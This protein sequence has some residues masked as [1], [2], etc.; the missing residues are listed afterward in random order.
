MF[1][2]VDANNF[3]V[4]CERVFNPKLEGRP[5]V[6]LSNNDGCAVAR[7][8]E[9]KALGVKMGAPWFAM[10]ELAKKHGIVA[11]S[12]NYTLYGDMSDRVV[13]IL[14]GY[15]PHVEVYSIDESFLQLDGLIGLWPTFTELG[16]HIRERV[17]MWTGLPVCAG[18]AP[19]KT[20][21]KLSNHL[22]KKNAEFNGVCDFNALS[23][24]D[25]HRYLSKL[26]VQEVWGVGRK[27]SV[28][29][30]SLGIES[31]QDLRTA[32]P[33]RI[34]DRFGVVLERTVN[35]LN[36]M[37]C[38]ALEEVAP[39][40]QQ[41]ISSRSFGEMVTTFDGLRE[42]VSTY[43]TT[44]AEKL[45]GDDG[46]CNVVS[47]YIE[48][49]RFREQ[50]RQYNNSMTVPLTEAT[51]DTRRLIA[52][53]LFGLKRIYRSGYLY[54]KAGIVLMQI[55]PASM[56]QQLLFKDENPKSAKVMLAMDALNGA[57][58]RNT[59]SLASSGIEKH[60]T[61]KFETRTPHYTTDWSQLPIAKAG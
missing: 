41:I 26:D 31:V 15:A 4:S 57:Y 49:N 27:L 56:R 25:I 22:A 33:K 60:W 50:D 37:S 47:V 39:V 40:R 51:S 36:S 18:I 42:A 20:L 10:K 29:L 3:Y 44:A 38:L 52:A 11:L 28:Q 16:Q 61:A 55:Q 1:A 54:K 53:A 23:E 19:S 8:N 14:K 9:V 45:R 46:V 35:E 17:R 24:S 21:A 5:V 59:I 32:N 58:G 30:I 48:T 34:R 13:Q 2:L 43:V 12:S 6:V 7:S